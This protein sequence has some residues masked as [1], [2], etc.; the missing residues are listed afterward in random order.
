[1]CPSHFDLSDFSICTGSKFTFQLYAHFLFFLSNTLFINIFVYLSQ[2]NIFSYYC[3]DT[4]LHLS[5][6]SC[7]YILS[8]FNNILSHI[9][10]YLFI[11]FSFI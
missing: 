11:Y 10:S 9:L 8:C 6:I 4:N 7:L 1:M 5:Y 2:Y 3:W